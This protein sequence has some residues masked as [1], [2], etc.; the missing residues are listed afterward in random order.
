M[1]TLLLGLKDN[2]IH[3][4]C[5][6]C[7]CKSESRSRYRVMSEI[8]RIYKD[9]N[10]QLYAKIKDTK[11]I[12]LYLSAI[13]LDAI[14]SNFNE[15]KESITCIDVLLGNEDTRY[16]IIYSNINL[17]QRVY[18][19]LTARVLGSNKE[20]FYVEDYIHESIEELRKWGK[21]PLYLG[22][23]YF[24]LGYKAYT[25]ILRT[26]LNKEYNNKIIDYLK[27]HLTIAKQDK[28]KGLK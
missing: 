24:R 4:V 11:S 27:L 15:L 23:Y 7:Y 12:E 21:R 17:V 2:N 14:F 1:N 20:Y 3:D 26:M 18:H 19:R 13:G 22:I 5:Y 28:R 10:I 8:D 6:Y 16:C 25:K 9:G